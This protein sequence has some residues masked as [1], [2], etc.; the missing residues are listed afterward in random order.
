[1]TYKGW[2]QMTDMI[3]FKHF[4]LFGTSTCPWIFSRRL[5]NAEFVWCTLPCKAFLR[6]IFKLFLMNK[7]AQTA[8]KVF[9]ANV[10]IPNRNLSKEF[11]LNVFIIEATD[12][13]KIAFFCSL[14]V[15][16]SYM[17]HAKR[18]MANC[19]GQR[20]QFYESKKKF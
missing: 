3:F 9:V 15:I 4:L 13:L 20:L 16:K 7:F 17:C 10:A 12:C 14:Q 1:M 6:K 11:H 5:D 18:S 19:A 8:L 2:L